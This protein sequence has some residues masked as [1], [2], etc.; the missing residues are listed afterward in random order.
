MKKEQVL[1]LRRE[2]LIECAK[3]IKVPHLSITDF[4]WTVNNTMK[5]F[6]KQNMIIFIDDDGETRVLKNRYGDTGKIIR[7]RKKYLTVD[8]E[9]RPLRLGGAIF[10]NK[11]TH[12]IIVPNESKN[13]K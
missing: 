3:E 12:K 5:L 10:F 6:A 9:T 8:I 11:A 1:I 13:S 7:K 4:K 2:D